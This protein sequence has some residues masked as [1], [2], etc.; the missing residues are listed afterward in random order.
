M[1][2]EG[3]DMTIDLLLEKYLTAFK[4]Y[5]H[6]LEVFENPT[7]K[8]MRGWEDRFRFIIDAKRQ[9]MYMWPATGA[10]HQDAWLHIKKRLND[11]RPLY[12]SATLIPC[13][14]ENGYIFIYGSAGIPRSIAQQYDYEDWSFAKKYIP[15]EEFY[16]EI[17]KLQ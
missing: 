8:E 11:N 4:K 3:M 17:R 1:N 9:K 12:K 15:M 2:L 14:Y 7:K 6:T 5:G 16:K 13:V 10:I